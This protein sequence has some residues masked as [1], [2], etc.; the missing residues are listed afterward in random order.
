[1]SSPETYLVDGEQLSA[2]QCRALVGAIPLLDRQH[3]VLER[4]E[5]DMIVDLGCYSGLFVHEAIRRFPDKSV[6]GVDYSEDNI[7]IA[8]YL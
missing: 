3:K 8:R 4:I 6:I 7:R 5:G 2:A 1:M